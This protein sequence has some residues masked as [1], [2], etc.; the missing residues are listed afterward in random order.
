MMTSRDFRNIFDL[1][2]FSQ[3]QDCLGSLV[4]VPH[5]ASFLGHC[6]PQEWLVWGHVSFFVQLLGCCKSHFSYFLG[7]FLTHGLISCSSTFICC[8]VNGICCTVIK[9]DKPGC[10]PLLQ[11]S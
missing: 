7:G 11:S 6:L 8:F 1:S 2:V 4:L 10:D 3:V 5:L 9:R